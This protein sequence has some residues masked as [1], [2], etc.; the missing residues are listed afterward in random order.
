MLHVCKL[1]LEKSKKEVECEN[2]ELN[3][4]KNMISNIIYSKT[5]ISEPTKS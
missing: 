4:E 5:P 3:P 2:Y 1:K